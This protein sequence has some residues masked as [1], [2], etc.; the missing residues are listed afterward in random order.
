MID[1]MVRWGITQPDPALFERLEN[2][3]PGAARVRILDIGCGLGGSASYLAQRWAN[4]AHITGV[5]LSGAQAHFAKQ[6][7]RSRG[8]QNVE[9]MVS[10]AM[11][12]AFGAGCFDII[13]TLESETHM[14]DKERFVAEITRLLKPGGRMVTGTWNVRDTRTTPLTSAE[15]ERL[16]YMLDE[17]CSVKFDGIQESVELLE[18]HGLSDVRAENWAEAIMPSWRDAVLVALRDVR[19]LA[20]TSLKLSWSHI[21][22]AYTIMLFDSAFRKGLCE[23]G[24][25]QARKPE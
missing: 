1:E 12:Q 21:R 7:A 24:L 23:Y 16:Q 3:L 9:F 8:V 15:K 20:S 14:P 4:S 25:F 10:D 18:R 5:T 13:W 11:D 17:W 19:G 22:D 6:L 2:P